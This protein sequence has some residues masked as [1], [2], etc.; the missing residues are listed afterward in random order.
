M[1]VLLSWLEE[2]VRLT[3]SDRRTLAKRLPEIGIE[4]AGEEELEGE[5]VLDVEQTANRGDL[6]SVRGLARELGA[7]FGRKVSP[8]RAVRMES[9]GASMKGAVRIDRACGC[10]RYLGARIEGVRIGASPA[11]MAKKLRLSGYAVLNNVVDITNLLLAEFGQPL[12]AFDADRLSGGVHVRRARSGEKLAALDGKTYEVSGD[13]VIASG[14]RPVALAG[15]IGGSDTAVGEGT[16]TVFL[17]CAWFEPGTVRRTGRRLGIA[18]ESSIRFE[19]HVDP[20]GLDPV[21]FRAIELI[22]ELAGGRL[23]GIERVGGKIGEAAPIP[24]SGDAI[25]RV[26]GIRYAGIEVSRVL[27]RLGCGVRSLGR[28][29]W[30]VTPPSFR[31]DLVLEEDLIEEVA[32]LCGLDRI[33]ARRPKVWAA[34]ALP[35]RETALSRIRQAA[36]SAGLVETVSM[37]FVSAEALSVFHVNP[38]EAVPLENPLSRAASHLR[39]TLLPHLATAA[40]LNA[41]R[42]TTEAL[43]FFEAGP[44]FL[45]GDPPAEEIRL[46]VAV[47]G[48]T[49]PVHFSKHSHAADF[50]DLKGIL[51]TLV[52]QSGREIKSIG[53]VPAAVGGF[54][55]AE[56]CAVLIDGTSI[57]C[58]GRMEAGIAQSMDLPAET[59][60]AELSL[61]RLL[62][63]PAVRP[64]HRAIPRFPAIRRDLSLLVRDEVTAGQVY[65]AI[66]STKATNLSRYEVFDLYR[67]KGVAPGM[68]AIGLTFIFQSP[69]RTLS[70]DEAN[71]ARDVIYG[72]LRERLGAALRA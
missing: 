61:S 3:A 24:L 18:T 43:R 59:Y 17:E 70:D 23:T 20:A 69:D 58:A 65:E 62:A 33:P 15:V 31:P 9:R 8:T 63:F 22:G 2:H 53:F 36:L 1:K 42:G 54:A 51:E 44:I 29:R 64:R 68:Y 57:G 72:V 41:R 46:A 39:P 48:P 35:E 40:S 47:A 7:A 10:R 37:S 66:D 45:P 13:L 26:L 34:S 19:R 60:L 12:H 25:E 5:R 38:A 11:A 52:G 32:R 14:D 30:V 49:A 71:A 50:F 27:A 67:G 56:S 4:V 6:L 16:R 28:E 21:F 55:D